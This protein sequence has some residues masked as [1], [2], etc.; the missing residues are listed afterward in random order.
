M[1]NQA[2]IDML[3][4]MKMSAMAA[5]VANQW[6]TPARTGVGWGDP[7]AFLVNAE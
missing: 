5:E 4:A 2:T 1:L 3:T 6:Q 7:V